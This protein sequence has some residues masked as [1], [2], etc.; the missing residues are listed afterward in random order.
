MAL[1]VKDRVKET[2]TTTGTGTVTLAGAETGFQ[3]FSVIGDGN[4]TYYTIESGNDWE[5]G[6]GTYTASGTTLSRDTILES[7][8]AGSAI[9]LSGTSTVFCTYPAERS[10]NTADIG[11][12]IQA[13]DANTAK[14]DDATANFTGT[15]QQ[16]GSNVLTGN[17]T[18]TLSGDATGSGTTAITVT[19][20]DDSHNHII[21][22]IDGLQTELDGKAAYDTATSSTGYFDVPAGTT[23]QRPG[24][25]TSGNIRYNTDESE[26]ELYNG[27]A[28]KIVDTSSYP[29]DVEYVVVAGGGGGG[30]TRGGG[31]GAGGY[32]S[33]V[34]GEN[35]GGGN[36]AES[37]LT[38]TP[39]TTYTVTIGGGG[40]G[41]IYSPGTPGSNGSNSVF[42]SITSTGGGR[43]GGRQS[44][45]SQ[46]GG[47]GGGGGSDYFS[48]SAGTSGQGY[49]GG[50]TSFTNYGAGGG[51]AAA[52]GQS[53]SSAGGNGGTGVASSITGSSVTRAGGGGGGA[54]SGT[55]G[56]GG[57]G[58]GGNGGLGGGNTGSAGTV[59]TGGGGGGGGDDASGGNGGSGVV[60]LRMP[61]ANYS[62]TTTGS[63]TVTTDGSDTILTFTSSGSYTG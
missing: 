38:V 36:S 41:G 61:T 14:Y 2:T 33:S 26:L 15:L 56:T 30:T 32:R 60:L 52:V 6:I 51:G 47:S 42:G 21:S 19:V 7:S 35:S 53:V 48:G 63:P 10:V 8:N 44:G 4:T 11:S 20:A 43:G 5:V 57:A 46:S 27:S 39:G 22:N 49:A 17:Q 28:W 12:T 62:G 34:S 25:P 3:S 40:A 37:V 59:N 23:A 24:S 16:G 1:V 54:Y 29:Y 55:A 18:I 45:A 13:Y 58:G 50:T 9:T 31:A